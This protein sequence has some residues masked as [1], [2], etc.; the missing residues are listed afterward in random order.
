MS[1]D[2][3]VVGRL[4]GISHN[5]MN[6]C[7]TN[8]QNELGKEKIKVKVN[9]FMAKNIKKMCGIGTLMGVRGEISGDNSFDLIAK[10]VNYL[11]RNIEDL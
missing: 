4:V 2:V 9:D 3:C 5:I 1:N 7:A 8:S 10:K 11:T 6:I